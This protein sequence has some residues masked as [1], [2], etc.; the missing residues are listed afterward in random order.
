MVG[1]GGGGGGGYFANKT[2]V[3][4]YVQENEDGEMDVVYIDPFAVG[5]KIS[6]KCIGSNY[7]HDL[8]GEYKYP[9]GNHFFFIRNSFSRS[10]AWNSFCATNWAT[11]EDP[12]FLVC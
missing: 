4:L 12:H 5:K 6:T 9:D 8:T 10:H 1:G 3:V 11:I 2:W 7:R